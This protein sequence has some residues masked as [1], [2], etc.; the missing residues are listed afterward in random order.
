MALRSLYFKLRNQYGNPESDHRFNPHKEAALSFRPERA[1]EFA[2]R[3]IG[4][5]ACG[6]EK[7]LFE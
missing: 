3:A 1:D 7:C 5:S 4:A 2:L 6:V